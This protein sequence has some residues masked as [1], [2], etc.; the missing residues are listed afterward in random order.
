MTRIEIINS[1][2]KKFGYKSYLEIGCQ[3]NRTFFYV[4]CIKKVGVD[5]ISGGTHCMTS[6]KFFEHNK[7]K[8]DIIFIDGLHHSEQVDKDIVN[9]LRFLSENGT[10]VVHDL[11]P[12]EEVMQKVPRE[13]KAW[14]G[15]VWKS[16]VKM[17]QLDENLLMFVIDTDMGCGIIRRGSQIVLKVIKKQNLNWRNFVKNKQLWINVISI[18]EFEKYLTK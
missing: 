16:W 18:R 6:D 7:D 13:Q 8:Y 15:D 2:I 9:S 4:S 3:H 11:L 1:F 14:T 17:R 10:I 12:I 5:L